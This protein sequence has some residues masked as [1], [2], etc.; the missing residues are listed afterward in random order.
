MSDDPAP[1]RVRQPYLLIGLLAL[2]LGLFVGHFIAALVHVGWTIGPDLFTEM[3]TALIVGGLPEGIGA[4]I[5]LAL[6]GRGG[7]QSRGGLVWTFVRIASALALGHYLLII[8]TI[9]ALGHETFGAWFVD[10]V[11]T[12]VGYCLYAVT[13]IVPAA[14]IFASI[15][16]YPDRPSNPS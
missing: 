9:G 15:T 12:A 14:I 4:I 8:V 1:F 11:E 13:V 10:S 3:R 7:F 5:A 16:I 6:L 2:G